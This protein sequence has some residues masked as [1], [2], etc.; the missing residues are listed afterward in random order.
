MKMRTLAVIGVALLAGVAQAQQ[1]LSLSGRYHRD[2]PDFA[3]YP[4]GD[5]DLSYM[6]AWETHNEDALIQ[7][8]ADVC[9]VFDDNEAVD[10]AV[11]PQF[12]LLLKDRIYRGGLGVLSTYTKGD[13]E[14]EWM[15]M[16]WQFLLGLS[17]ELPAKL[18]LDAYAIYPFKDWGS[19]G[20][21]GVDHIEYSAGL[22]WH[23]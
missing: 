18:S 4:F 9:P 8:G 23:F 2:Q 3:E 19:L 16:Y 15:D 1:A 20:D 11:S 22:A 21:F 13:D 10:Y 12:N 5:G 14:D 17:F 7:I 6:V